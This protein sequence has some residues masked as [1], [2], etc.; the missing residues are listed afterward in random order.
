MNPKIIA[1]YLPQF[2]AIPENDL[3]WGKGFTEW[4]NTKK[5]KPLYKGH[6]QPKEPLDDNYY[7][8]LDAK[9]QEWQADL[10]RKYGI[11]GFCYYHYWFDG[12]LLLEKPMENMLKN[13][14]V[15]IPFCISWANETWSRTWSGKEKEILIQQKYG[16]EK[17][18]IKHIEY[19]LPFFKDKRYITIN[20]KPMLLLYTAS[21]IEHCEEMIRVWNEYLKTEGFDGIY[22]VETMNSF[23]KK[24]C[25]DMSEAE[26]YFEPWHTKAYL[27]DQKSAV[28]I[29]IKKI[30][31][32][33]SPKIG[34]I[35]AKQIWNTILLEKEREYRGKEIF[36][37]T[38]PQWDNTARRGKKAIIFKNTSVDN[39]AQHFKQLYKKSVEE[40]RKFIF[41]N[42]WNEWAEGA[43]LEPDKHNK[44]GYLESIKKVVDKYS[45][46]EV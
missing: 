17:D 38:F 11:D 14:K 2:H 21:R 26:V 10:A 18:W 28:K 29:L 43:Y 3:W 32:V 36:L 46:G 16:D 20:N 41:V 31:G 42:A 24:A 40:K 13:P 23:Q 34:C 37:G 25:L 39:F 30:I 1:F 15:N 45:A 35:D 6:Y 22:I 33:I 7:S 8:L 19:L 4:V 9:S 27:D 44:F 12:K 5:A